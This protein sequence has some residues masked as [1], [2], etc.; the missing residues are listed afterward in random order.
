[1]SD[2]IKCGACEYIC[3]QHL[4][5]RSLLEDVAAEFEK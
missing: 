5:I 2:C 3:P 4:E 1:A